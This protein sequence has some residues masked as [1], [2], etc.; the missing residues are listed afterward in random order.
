MKKA[1]TDN[2]DAFGQEL[3]KI[4]LRN[5]YID[6]LLK[7]TKGEEAVSLIKNVDQISAAGVFKLTKFTIILMCY[8][9]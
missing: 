6:N 7:S 4:L 8:L 5:F 9:Q 2:V 1:A 3:A